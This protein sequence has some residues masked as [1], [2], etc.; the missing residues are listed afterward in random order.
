MFKPFLSPEPP[1]LINNNRPFT[2]IG[3][4]PAEGGSPTSVRIEWP[5]PPVLFFRGYRAI[6]TFIP[7]TSSSRRKRQA[8]VT[9]NTTDNFIMI[10][11]FFG[12]ATYS[13]NVA[14]EIGPDG[15]DS[16]F[17]NVFPNDATFIAPERGGC[18][19]DTFPLM[20]V[21]VLP[22]YPHTLLPPHSLTP[23]NP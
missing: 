9:V 16:V 12:G 4:L 15:S 6:I 13:P 3:Q 21:L 2:A 23:N 10:N 22:F 1:V 18:S 17:V 19:N 11:D 20:F 14:A 7:F 8:P 5:I